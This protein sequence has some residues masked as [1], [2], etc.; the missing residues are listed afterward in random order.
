MFCTYLTIY[1]GDMM[2][3]YY[4]GSTSIENIINN[5]YYGS[6][7]SKR[8]KTIFKNELKNNPELFDII[9]LTEHDNRKDALKQELI[10]QIKVDCVR[11]NDYINRSLAKPN[12]YFGF[13]GAGIESNVYGLKRSKDSK[14]KYRLANLGENNPQYGKPSKRKGCTQIAWNKGIKMPN[15]SPKKGIPMSEEQKLKIKLSKQNISQE[16]RDKIRNSKLGIKQPRELV[17][18]RI[19]ASVAARKLNKELK[20]NIIKD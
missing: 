8:F 7:S 13:N 4:L 10:Y 1:S 18:R 9:I 2:P 14:E 6:I 20:L 19:A 12:G 3:K 5:N 16:T 17:E 15:P 11:N